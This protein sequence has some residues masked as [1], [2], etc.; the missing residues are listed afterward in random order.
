[1]KLVRGG[2]Y[3][4]VP[5]RKFPAGRETRWTWKSFVTV[6]KQNLMTLF[7]HTYL[8]SVLVVLDF[9]LS[10]LQAITQNTSEKVTGG[11]GGGGG[12]GG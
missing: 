6:Q 2:P 12:G 1:M 5:S 3:S 10:T 9:L 11:G 7:S 4:L 8:E